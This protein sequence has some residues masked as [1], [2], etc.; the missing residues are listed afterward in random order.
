MI[1][2]PLQSSPW[3]R[4]IGW[5][6]GDIP[7]L[8]LHDDINRSCCFRW[9][10]PSRWNLA[11]PKM[12]PAIVNGVP[13]Y[14]AYEYGQAL[15][16]DGSTAGLQFGNISSIYGAFPITFSVWLKLNSSAAGRIFEQWGSG[17]SNRNFLIATDS[18][19]NI[20]STAEGSSVS[21]TQAR[22][23]ASPSLTVGKLTHFLT[24]IGTGTDNHTMYLNGVLQGK[25]VTISGSTQPM[26][27]TAVNFEIGWESNENAAGIDGW[28]DNFG[29]WNRALSAT[30]AMRLWSEPFA[31]IAFGRG[32]LISSIVPSLITSGRRQTGV[33]VIT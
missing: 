9:I 6:P 11:P 24:V 16:L 13:K 7:S 15:R 28:V 20:F 2:N 29:I 21:I 22:P 33:S 27:G 12:V 4:P 17:A 14:Q 18:T 32:R 23:T 10:A 5:A 30:E 19:P 1:T 3:R 8:D 31:G 26:Q 25:T